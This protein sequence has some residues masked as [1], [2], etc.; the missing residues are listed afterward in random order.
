ML[1]CPFG[2]LALEVSTQDEVIRDR[3]RA[4]FDGYCS[5]FE[6]ALREA[7]AAGN[8]PD[9]DLSQRARALLAYFQ[10][11]ML[12]AKT[13]NDPSIVHTLADH[14]RALAGGRKDH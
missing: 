7:A 1:G 13:Q 11:A 5:Y 12:L 9:G 3:I 10:G 6:D 14:A 8:T 4:V 2:N